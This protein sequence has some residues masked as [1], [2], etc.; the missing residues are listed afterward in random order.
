MNVPSCEIKDNTVPYYDLW[1]DM[2]GQPPF[3]SAAQNKV[4][5]HLTNKQ[6]M[7]IFWIS[8]KQSEQEWSIVMY[9]NV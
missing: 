5:D 1:Q 4:E 9:S 7:Y 8:R 6:R 2:M 3:R